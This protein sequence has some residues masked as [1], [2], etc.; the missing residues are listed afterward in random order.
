MHWSLVHQHQ[1]N[2]VGWEQWKLQA[3]SPY[4]ST[5]HEELGSYPQRHYRFHPW[6]E[7]FLNW[8]FFYLVTAVFCFC[9]V[10]FKNQLGFFCPWCPLNKLRESCLTF[11]PPQKKNSEQGIL[12]QIHCKSIEEFVLSTGS[13][14]IWLSQ[15]LRP[16]TS[17]ISWNSVKTTVGNFFCFCL[18]FKQW[19][20]P[21][22]EVH[23]QTIYI[24]RQWALWLWRTLS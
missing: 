18:C 15:L 24:D 11:Q 21:K 20:P 10:W 5:L 7:L 12:E 19:Q 13:R 2:E 22:I 3:T 14:P 16:E 17:C 1:Q 6:I 23:W 9:N 8:A 4:C